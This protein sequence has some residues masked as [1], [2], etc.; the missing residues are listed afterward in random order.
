MLGIPRQMRLVII[1]W[2]N[3]LRRRGSL[4]TKLRQQELLL[5]FVWLV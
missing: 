2:D 3:L 1:T 4:I 5:L